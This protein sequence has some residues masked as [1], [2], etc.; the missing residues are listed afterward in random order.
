MLGKPNPIAKAPARIFA[1]GDYLITEG[2]QSG[3]LFVLESGSVEILRGGMVVAT[4]AETGAIIGEM[5]VLLDTPHSASVR[6]KTDTM[7]LVV[8]HARDSLKKHPE[9]LYKVAQILARRLS[10]TTTFLVDARSQFAGKEDLVFLE[11]VF[12][13][14][15]S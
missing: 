15:D 1:A 9:L 5:S 8:E 7:A 6:A 4:V 3:S 11:E 13:L 14:L 12:E 2:G 10:A